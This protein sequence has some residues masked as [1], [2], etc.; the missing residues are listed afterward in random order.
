MPRAIWKL[1]AKA[2]VEC[3]A[4]GRATK[5]QVVEDVLEHIGKFDGRVHAFCTLMGKEHGIGKEGRLSGVPISVKDLIDTK[6]MRTTYGS[7][8]HSERVPDQDDV[9]VERLRAAGATIVGK[10]NTSEFG[11]IASCHNNLFETTRNPWN[12][13]RN[14]G[15][16]SGGAAAAVASGMGSIAVGS[17]GGGSVRLP[18]ALCGVVGFKPSFGVIPSWPGC[19]NP[20]LPGCSSWE[21]LEVLG[22]L[23]RTVQDI[24]LTM[25]CIEGPDLRDRH[26]LPTLGIDWENAAATNIDGLRIAYTVDFGG[27]VTVDPEVRRV[28]LQAIGRLKEQL[29]ARVSFQEASPVVPEL[30]KTF[31]AL[32]ARDSD[33]RGMR[34]MINETGASKML[35]DMVGLVAAPWTAEDFTDAAM[36][37][38][39]VCNDM[40]KFMRSY[41]ILLTPTVPCLAFE[42]NVAAPTTIDFQS[43]SNTHFL[44]F[45]RVFNLTRQPA[46]SV[47]AGFSKDKLPV[48][49]QIVGRRLEDAKV[50][51]LAAAWECISPW[52]DIWPPMLENP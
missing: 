13:D 38:Q 33:L 21:T 51:G 28:F 7:M 20:D 30:D 16:S 29:G 40:A 37:Q 25:S 18:A 32:I 34:K 10:T 49:L 42:L 5:E 19:R 47:P 22:L 17:D 9:V 27:L 45:C 35:S 15:G 12:L 43:V 3:V 24:C 1:N 8:V 46:I 11:Y 31:G 44:S 4:S 36:V 6:G 50:L 48:G 2:Q 23:S 26:S 52:K 39:K 14:C 41:D